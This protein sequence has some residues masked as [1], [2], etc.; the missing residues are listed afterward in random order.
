[1]QSLWLERTVLQIES[2]LPGILRWFPVT[3]ARRELI[4]PVRHGCETVSTANHQLRQLI[5]QYSPPGEE[6]NISPLSM[7]LQVRGTSVSPFSMRLQAR[8][9][10]ISA[11][12][13]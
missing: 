5:G 8:E 1:M 12:S 3:G 10:L 9:G 13:V 4:S 6:T 11:R 7:R 2:P